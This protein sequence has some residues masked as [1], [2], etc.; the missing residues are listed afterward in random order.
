M[1]IKTGVVILTYN[2]LSLL[3][4]T[5]CKVLAQ[6]YKPE[7]ILVIDNASTDGTRDY[8]NTIEGITTMFLEENSG[9]AGGFYE[10]V[11]YFAENSS[12]DYIW[13]MDDDFFPFDSCL[14]ILLENSDQESLVYPYVREKDFASRRQ[15]GWWGV[16]LPMNIVKKVGYPRKDLFFWWE[17]TEY[18]QHRI[19]E[20]NNYVSRW[21]PA[22]KGVH[23][24]KRETNYR[25][26][27][28]YYY[29]IRNSSYSRLYVKKKT[30]KRAYKFFR[31]WVKLCGS[32]I[33][34]ENNKKEKM[35]LFLRGSA[36]GIMK[37][38][39]KRVDP[40]LHR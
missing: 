29:E 20:K 31:S 24:T 16:L 23:F 32:I 36:D 27:W 21:I 38:L 11:K 3:K 40:D 39:G 18:L 10:G 2:R 5:I 25:Q 14:E 28:R 35:K 6:T 22:A 34:K 7:E 1:N 17:D 8:L 30:W 37:R 12:V 13:L 19:T 26:P 33:L 9:P 4:I 15:P